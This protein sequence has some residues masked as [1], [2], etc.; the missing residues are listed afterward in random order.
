M[1]L[2]HG[3]IRV[4]PTGEAL[5]KRLGVSI[6]NLH[7]QGWGW[8]VSANWG[9]KA[10]WGDRKEDLWEARCLMGGETGT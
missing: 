7:F 5:S 2:G 8:K 3:I 10:G 9:A 4:V 6:R 1:E